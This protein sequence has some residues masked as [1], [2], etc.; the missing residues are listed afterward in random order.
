MRACA[1]A[2]E[3]EGAREWILR[4]KSTAISIYSSIFPENFTSEMDHPSTPSDS[5]AAAP[6]ALRVAVGRKGKVGSTRASSSIGRGSSRA[7]G[8]FPVGG[9]SGSAAGLLPFGHGSSPPAGLLPFG[10]GSMAAST[11]AESSPIGFP[12]PP[13]PPAG[14]SP[15]SSSVR[16]SDATW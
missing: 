14:A 11:A 12:F 16:H 2:E 1:R 8:L 15:G 3:V 9:R 6:A 4:A 7:A 5:G 10:R 13:S